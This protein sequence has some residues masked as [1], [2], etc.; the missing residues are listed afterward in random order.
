LNSSARVK[1]LGSIMSI[2]LSPGCS[3]KS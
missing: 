2:S 1:S 3:K